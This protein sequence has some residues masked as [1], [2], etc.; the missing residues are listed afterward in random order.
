V[1]MRSIGCASGSRKV[2]VSLPFCCLRTSDA[3]KLGF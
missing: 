2:L 3:H 1:G